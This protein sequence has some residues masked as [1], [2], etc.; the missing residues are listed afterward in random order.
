VADLG[1]DGAA[2]LVACST[3]S[4][5]L[6]TPAEQ[7]AMTGVLGRWLNSLTGPAQVVIRAER[8]DLG[9]A[10]ER[11]EQA[12][13]GLPHPALEEAALEHAAFLADVAACCDLLFRQVLVVLRET[14]PGAGRDTAAARALAAAGVT[15]RVLDGAEAAALIAAACDPYNPAPAGN[16]D[17]V[18]TRGQR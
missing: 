12:A 16:P 2:V 7:E 13:P 3:V 8:V 18:I 14:A 5:A 4:F 10:I 17:T 1:A 6:A 15:A 11:L 9:P